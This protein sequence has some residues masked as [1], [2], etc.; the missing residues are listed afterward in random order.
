M[1]IALTQM[2][3]HFFTLQATGRAQLIIER[4]QAGHCNSYISS[5]FQSAADP[6]HHT[7]PEDLSLLQL[8]TK[9]KE[10]PTLH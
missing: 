7:S 3:S 10:T 5:G 2:P 1:T 6:K 8:P 9:A 4:K